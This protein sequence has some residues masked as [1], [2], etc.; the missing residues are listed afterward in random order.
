MIDIRTSFLSDFFIS[1]AEFSSKE[2]CEI[3][4]F[5]LE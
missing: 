4:D 3:S 2:I 1:E 5:H